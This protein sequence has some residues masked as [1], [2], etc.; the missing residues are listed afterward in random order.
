MGLTRLGKPG[1][2]PKRASA[3]HGTAQQRTSDDWSPNT[4]ARFGSEG[5]SILFQLLLE[6]QMPAKKV[7]KQKKVRQNTRAFARAG[8]SACAPTMKLYGVAVKRGKKK[9]WEWRMPGLKTPL[10]RSER[11]T[12][13]GK[14]KNMKGF[15]VGPEKETYAVEFEWTRISPRASGKSID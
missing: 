15:L 6:Q 7:S 10:A 12:G 3:R 8:L 9:V 2:L 4:R 1:R 11:I 5:D 14:Q 13:R